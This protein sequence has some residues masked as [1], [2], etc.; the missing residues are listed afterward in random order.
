[1]RRDVGILKTLGVSPAQ[2]F[3]A[4]LGEGLLFGV[5]GSAL[6]IALGNALAFG[7][8]KLIGRTI[9][10]LYVTSAPEAIAL[11]PGVVI[12][13]MAVGTLLSL[14][15]AIQPS[16][17]AAQ[18]PPSALIRAGLQQ[19][20]TRGGALAAAALAC[21]AIPALVSRLPPVR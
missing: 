8:L 17:E 3:G 19:R 18:V 6:G 1:R 14:V 5:I 9:N 12:T 21:F 20:L 13:G 15:S 10:S 11:T 2:I 4:F 7:I 16:L